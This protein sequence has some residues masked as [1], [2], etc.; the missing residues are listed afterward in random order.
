MLAK[1]P[2]GAVLGIDGYPVCV[3]VD[4]SAGL[5]SFEVVGLPDAA[6]REARERV[7]AA[8]RNSGFE[9]PLRRITVNLAPAM[10][11]KEGAC[12]DLAIALGILAATGEISSSAVEDCVFAGELSLDGQ[13]RGTSGV[14]SIALA[15]RSAG[16]TMMMVASENAGEAALVDG[17]DVYGVN[18]LVEAVGHLCGSLRISKTPATRGFADASLQFEEDLDFADVLGQDQARRALEVAAAGGHNVLMVGPPGAGKTMLARRIPSVLPPLTWDEALEV[19][20]VYSAAGLLPAGTSVVSTRP[21]RSPHHTISAPGLIG[22]GRV[23]RP[24]EISLAH[25]GVLFL[26]EI[27]EFAGHALEALRQ[28]LEDGF[29]TV[30]RAGGM[31]T[32]PARFM[33]VAAMNPCPCGRGGA[34]SGVCTC[35]PTAVQKYLARLSGPLLDRIDLH[36]HVRKVDM[37]DLEQARGR[38]TSAEIRERVVRARQTQQARF[39]GLPVRANAEMR[40][41]ELR[42]FCRMSREARTLLYA[43]CARLGLSAR[44]HAR[45]LKVARTIADLEGSD[46]VQDQHI[47]EA[48][49]YRAFSLRG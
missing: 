28:P 26:D 44:A 29:V 23:P 40:P 36:I 11:R 42:A 30:S 43:A 12:F 32:F 7:R 18:T 4:V 21:F 9:F 6:I 49:S 16:F 3:E 25:R 10:I 31:A 39:G 13:V 2:G 46:L 19:T 48:V 27:P 33:L 20:R 22:G 15:A 37:N 35:T 45:V 5:P 38:E 24:G 47:S 14:L 34:R 41:S 1:V 8:L 17:L